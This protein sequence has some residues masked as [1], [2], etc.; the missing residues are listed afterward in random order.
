MVESKS[1]TTGDVFLSL[2]QMAPAINMLENSSSEHIEFRKQCVQFYNKPWKEFDITMYLLAYFLHPKYRGKGM[3]D[4]VFHQILCT[5]LE[6][7]KKIT[8][9]KGGVT[10]ANILIAQLK[11]YDAYEPPYNFTFVEGIESPKT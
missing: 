11:K 6:I 3:K 5:A 9:G 7:W 2:I 4:S 8:N 10:S 1:T